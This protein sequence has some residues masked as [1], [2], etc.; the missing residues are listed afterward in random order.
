M[1]PKRAPYHLKFREGAIS[2][3]FFA[4]EGF[5]DRTIAWPKELPQDTV[6]REG[7][8]FRYV[9]EKKSRL[10]ELLGTL[11]PRCT[12]KIR[13]VDFHRFEP[14][15]SE[16]QLAVVLRDLL[17]GVSEVVVDI[18]VMSKLMIMMLL[19]ALRDFG[20]TLNIIYS[21]PVSYAPSEQDY[22]KY[23]DNLEGALTLPS[24]GVHQVVRTP[25]L[26]SAIMQRHPSLVVAFTS[27][28][29]QL[30]RALLSN[31]SPARFFLVN[32]V[33]PRLKWRAIAAQEIHR[34]VIE[35]YAY[36]NE[37]E[38]GELK[39]R[40]STL[41][42]EETFTL[43][44]NIYKNHCYTH[45][46]IVAPTG[47]KMQAVAAALF[48]ICCPDVHIEYPTPESFFIEGFSSPDIEGIHQI[49]FSQFAPFV[50]GLGREYSLNG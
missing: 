9:P 46:I 13:V 6:F 37:L 18:S 28:N 48:K 30:I 11:Q 34:L 23:K 7:L 2:R 50:S 22:L 44:S 14:A 12:Q 41:D 49:T 16:L 20:G 47:S 31:I 3:I 42:Y 19:Y 15:R 24:Y 10:E 5:E 8:V 21:E 17:R 35:E 29:E 4:A 40:C 26:S 36:D 27:F 43:L 38:G 33:P 39:R 1:L 32:S 25:A 45:R